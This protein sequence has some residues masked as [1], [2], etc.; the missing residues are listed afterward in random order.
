MVKKVEP[1]TYNISHQLAYLKYIKQ[2]KIKKISKKNTDNDLIS[3]I[4]IGTENIEKCIKSIKKQKYK[5]FEILLYKNN[6]KKYET[7]SGFESIHS[8]CCLIM[9]SNC[10]LDENCLSYFSFYKKN[11][12][13]IYCD[14]DMLD[15]NDYRLEPKFKPDYSPDTLLS[16]NYIGS[17]IFLKTSLIKSIKF[18]TLYDMI[19][20]IID[21]NTKIYHIPEILYHEYDKKDVEEKVSPEW[22]RC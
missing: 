8:N 17:L 13:V 11:N 7:I 15:T 3:I 16:T 19:L 12:D 4:I 14:N 22:Q 21:N 1:G 9:N 6:Y 2:N 10:I 18:N 20:N 5:N